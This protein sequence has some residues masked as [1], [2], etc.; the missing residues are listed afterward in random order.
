MRWLV[1]MAAALL[2]CA[3]PG[4]AD[5]ATERKAR[6]VAVLEAEGVPLIDHLPVI[7]TGA[8]SLRRDREQV[9]R[10]AVA[11]TIVAVKGETGDHALAEHLVAQFGAEGFF[12]PA[13]QAFMDDPAP[14]AH[15]RIQ[16]TWRY[17]GVHVMLWALGITGDL[18][19]PDAIV[20]VPLL[21]ETLRDLGTEG[22]RARADLRP[23]AEILDAAD[24]I[25]RYHWAVVE[26]RLQGQ[27]APARLDPGVVLERHH[28]LNW[29]IGY[30]GQDWDD[31]ST[32]T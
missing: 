29:L 31:V 14:D 8:Q 20:D 26:A 15:S 5:E 30:R 24:L 6:S 11:L 22:L 4:A 1:M 19:R 27:P 21:A 9:I 23:K 10:R 13:E 28:A 12:T 7:E 16:F 32:D 2:I 18:G 25:Y 17:E 3:G